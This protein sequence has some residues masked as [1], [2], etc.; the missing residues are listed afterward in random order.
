MLPFHEMDRSY[1]LLVEKKYHQDQFLVLPKYMLDFLQELIPHQ[2]QSI[3][4]QQFFQDSPY[5]YLLPTLTFPISP[6]VFITIVLEGSERKQTLRFQR[7]VMNPLSYLSPLLPQ[8]F[9]IFK[10]VERQLN[11]PPLLLD[12]PLL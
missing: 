8:L 10:L 11:A 2:L 12:H 3:R 6:R 7:G 1:T 4:Y 9:D 5:Y